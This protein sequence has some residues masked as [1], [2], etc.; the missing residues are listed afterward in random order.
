MKR[1]A[2]IVVLFLLSCGVPTHIAQGQKPA[3]SDKSTASDAISGRYEGLVKGPSVGDMY[4]TMEIKNDGGNITGVIV[5]S[6]STIKIISGD[7]ALNRLSVKFQVGGSDVVISAV[8]QDS[9]LVGNYTLAGETGTVELKRIA[10]QR[11]ASTAINR[12]SEKEWRDDLHYLASEL[13]KRHKNAFHHTTRE[14]FEQEV[15]NLD[16]AIPSLQP[17]QIIIGMLEITA[18]VGDAHTYVHLPRSF[19]HYPL[20]LYWFGNELRVTRTTTPYQ[21]ALGA[22]VVRIGEMNIR[23]L[24]RQIRRVISQ[25]ETEWFVLRDSPDYM[26]IPEVL[27]S[28]GIVPNITS[29][30]F[31]FMDD[32]GKQFTLNIEAVARGEKLNWL[33]LPTKLPLYQQKPGEQF[34]FTYLPDAKTVYVSFRGYDSLIENA[35]QLFTFIDQHQPERLVI[36]MRENGGG[37]FTLVREHLLPALKQRLAINRTGHLFVVIGRDTFSAAMS[38]ATD[39]R[40]ETK[41]ILVGEPIGERPNSYQENRQLVLPNSLL[42]VSYST[43]YYKFLDGVSE[44]TPDKRINLDWLEYKAGR[45]PVMEW[46]LAYSPKSNRHHLRGKAIKSSGRVKSEVELL[47]GE[48]SETERA[49]LPGLK[50]ILIH[51]GELVN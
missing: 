47:G 4:I 43:Q 48:Q 51:S 11:E 15:T 2:T 28:L 36:D 1:L 14:Q 16:A 37:D 49:L 8:Y 5:A 38:N 21:R 32:Q 39:L 34:W 23:K 46:I 17:D 19:H 25:A 31:T 40:K 3:D 13:P 22:R 9:K 50:H 24:S 45:D 35:Q 41:A 6:G 20:A 30:P 10:N 26:T 29:A 18:K 42:M 12:L 33:S 27:H 44:V 7:Y